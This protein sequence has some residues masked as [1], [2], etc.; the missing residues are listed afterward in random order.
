MKWR[1]FLQSL[2][3]AAVAPKIVT[4]VAK[5]IEPGGVVLRVG[6]V[7]SRIMV[8]QTS[9]DGGKT[10]NHVANLTKN[11]MRPLT[12]TEEKIRNLVNG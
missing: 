2:A 7:N 9:Q 3:I 1:N 10:W 5:E 8:L 12:P 4:E 11:S 6:S